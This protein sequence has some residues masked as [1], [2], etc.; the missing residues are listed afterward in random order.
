[1]RYQLLK[2]SPYLGGQIR[3]DIPMYYHYDNGVHVMDT[4]ELHIV[5]LD[6]NIVFNEGNSR[7]TFNY[8]HL[9]N[10]KHLFGEIGNAFYSAE[11]EWNGDHWL[12]N[13]GD[14]VDP[15]SHIFNMG[16]RRTRFSRYDKQFSYLCPLWI[17]EETDPSRL[18]FEFSIKVSGEE[19]DHIVRRVLVLSDNI[20]KYM[21][22]YLNKS[23][24]YSSPDPSA[25]NP[26]YQGVNDDLLSIK[27]NPDYAFIT[28][29][30]ADKGRYAT[31]DISYVIRDLVHREIPMM[32]FDNMLLSKFR[33]SNMVA[34]QLIN[35]NFLFNMEDIS[36]VLKESLNG[37]HITVALRVKYDG[38]YLPLKDLYT[39]YSKI[40]VYRVDRSVMSNSKNVC[41]YIGDNKII[42]YIYTNKFTQP[43]FHWA[44]VENPTYIYNFYDGFAPVFKDNNEFYRVEGRYYDQ[45]EI[46]QENHNVYNSAASWCKVIDCKG[47]TGT[48]TIEYNLLINRDLDHQAS[49]LFMNF[50][51]GVAY[52]NNNMYD[53]TK[54]N[55]EL[56]GVKKLPPIYIYS[57]IKDAG[58]ISCSDVQVDNTL[59]ASMIISKT[60]DRILI[61]FEN[62]DIVY[63]TYM[64]YAALMQSI[65]SSDSLGSPV[66]TNEDQVHRKFGIYMAD[67]TSPNVGEDYQII[68]FLTDL[69]N[70]WIPPYRINFTRGT[71]TDTVESFGKYHPEERRMYKNNTHSGYVLRYTGRLCPFF[72]DPTDENYRNISYRYK[73]WSDI[74]SKNVQKYND[75]LK[76]G[77]LPEYPS[78]GYYSFEE[79]DDALTRPS[80]YEEN[81][82]PWDIVW[83]NDGCVY[84]LPE[85]YVASTD[86]M[87]TLSFD[88]KNEELEMWELL[89]KHIN[90]IGI[91]VD[92][93]WM[94]HKLKEL[95]NIS[96]NFEYASETDVE[97]I[98]YHVRFRLR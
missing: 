85:Q 87:P 33:E 55:L 59:N 78:V 46:T 84:I 27:F 52:L 97:H 86:P 73:Q 20:C 31:R 10:I 61:R 35:L 5:P 56:Y 76:T 69:F 60:D 23:A 43:I 53:L 34:Q 8:T 58:Q 89:Y 77:M 1:M 3:W 88:E 54:L 64:R 7:E 18:E 39:N 14:I 79:E 92:S 47:F 51:T 11:G 40:P 4:P 91:P 72:V 75:F 2:T 65:V 71:I 62:D 50:D 74:T 68:K 32:E 44:M 98:I 38:E 16:A 22:E 9:E 66:S 45:A 19:R 42:D 30:Q 70:T 6:D 26:G 48:M 29:V 83:K 37:K 21:A 49:R 12:Y 13:N 24:R 81:K 57:M 80:W 17:S 63:S 41:D 90:E 28:G 95:Y 15:Y 25:P 82:W 96:Y 93:L 67:G 94:K 36:Y